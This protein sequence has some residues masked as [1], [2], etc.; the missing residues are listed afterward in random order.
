MVQQQNRNNPLSLLKEIQQD[1]FGLSPWLAQTDPQFFSQEEAWL[2]KV[3]IKEEAKEYVVY[4]DLP[5]VKAEDVQVELNGNNLTIK[6]E[7][8]SEK[9][10][11]GKNFYRSECKTG[12]FYRQ[13]SLPESVDS[14]KIVAKVKHGVLVL[15]L[16]KIEAGKLSRKVE[17]RQE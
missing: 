14:N 10:E 13:F 15:H 12:R 2:P 1:L 17:V 16:P 11:K 3:D 5:G 8:R 4:A 6:G 9:E 7:R